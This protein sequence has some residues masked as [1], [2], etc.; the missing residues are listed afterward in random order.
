MSYTMCARLDVPFT[1]AVEATRSALSDQGF[2]VISEIDLS[3]TLRAKIGVELPDQVILGACRPPL[4]HAAVLADPSIAA[5]L[6]CNVVVRR[7]DETTS[8][9]EAIDP[10]VMTSLSDS[11]ALTGV[12][13]DARTRIAAALAALSEAAA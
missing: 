9:V 8:M 2:G 5:L 12:A 4:A 6:P 1:Q 3:G 11:P 10:G 7:I 13:E